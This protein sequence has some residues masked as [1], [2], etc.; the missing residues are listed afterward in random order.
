M[1][2]A[3]EKLLQ[4]TSKGVQ[5]QALLALED[6]TVF[7]GRSCGAPGE[8]SGEV[9]FNTSLEG[10]LEVITDPSYAGQIITMTYP[11]IG[12]YGVHIDDVQRSHIHARGLVVRDMCATP[13]SWRCQ[14]SLPEFLKQEGVVA[15]EGIDTRALVRHIRENG[16]MQGV[17]STEDL[18]AA[19]LVA[20]AQA[21]PRLVGANM[22]ETVSDC[23][24]R[25]FDALPPSHAFATHAP[26]A[27]D[28][29]VVVF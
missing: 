10:Y 12:N 3:A 19:S 27:A 25:T 21:A 20:K 15:I 13:A 14:L 28:K 11:Q 24:P 5:A 17:L 6:G 8:V 29:T 2:N 9:C 7:V 18:D 26:A 1:S 16:A 22:V 4:N 23:T